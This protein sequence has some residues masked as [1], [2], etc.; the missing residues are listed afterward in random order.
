M[1]EVG[2]G[3]EILEKKLLPVRVKD[4]CERGISNLIECRVGS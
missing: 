4:V 1:R 2:R 3:V